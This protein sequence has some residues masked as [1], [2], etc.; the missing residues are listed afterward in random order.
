MQNGHYND[1]PPR[2]IFPLTNSMIHSPQNLRIG[3]L[4]D[5]SIRYSA[6]ETEGWTDITSTLPALVQSL[7]VP[8]YPSHPRYQ[9][10]R[11][12]SS[13]FSSQQ[14]MGGPTLPNSTYSSRSIRHSAIRT[15]LRMS[16]YDLSLH[17]ICQGS[18]GTVVG[19]QD[20]PFKCN[21]CPQKF[22]RK[23]DLNR[24]KRIHMGV[25]PFSCPTCDKSFS[26]KDALK[27]LPTDYYSNCVRDTVS[28]AVMPKPKTSPSR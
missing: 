11:L 12:A 25:K 17:M 13:Y 9:Q 20:R 3:S 14:Y 27:V 1:N 10:P 5:S 15:P 4:Y 16:P 2:E 6:S 22:N 18:G 24:H 23:N 19:K 21:Q 28:F 26:R 8:S 7:A